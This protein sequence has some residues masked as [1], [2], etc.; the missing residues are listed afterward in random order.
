MENISSSRTF[1]E[2]PLWNSN[3]TWFTDNPDF[4]TCFHETVLVYLPAA[5]LI[6]FAPIEF[7]FT[8]RQSK[9]SKVPWSILNILRTIFTSVLILLP[10]IDIAYEI[11]IDAYDVHLVSAVVKLIS[12]SLAL[13]LH[14]ICKRKGL[15]TSG[16]LTFFWLVATICGI[17]TFRSVISTPYVSGKDAILP[18]TTYTVQFPLVAA[19]FLLACFADPKPK[20][21]NVEGK[22]KIT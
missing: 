7:L 10:I 14:M 15:V 1:C 20:Y 19:I 22:N 12:Y 18:F 4:T 21:I 5:I 17:F 3:L 9:D 16:T 6:I 11:R 8:I 13:A 2:D